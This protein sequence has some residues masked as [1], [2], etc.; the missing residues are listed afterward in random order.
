M[1]RSGNSERR[2]EPWKTLNSTYLQRSRWRSLRVDRLRLP[3][4][5]EISYTYC[6]TP[7]AVLIVPLMADRQIVLIHQYRY[8]VRS[9]VWEV[10]GGAVGDEP[11]DASARRE[12]A[13]E[14]GGHCGELIPLGWAY[15]SPAHLTAREYVFLAL[16]VELGTASREPTE[17]LEVIPMDAE[18]AFARARDGRITDGQSALALLKAE[19]LIHARLRH[20][21]RPGS[22]GA[23][24]PLDDCAPRGR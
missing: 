7:A 8:P 5:D 11:A 12:L 13:E 21:G 22:A 14:I 6:E 4:G 24:S 18:E 10:P 19:P 3:S 17:L 9:W 23:G 1:T 2:A 16:D 20:A 15:T